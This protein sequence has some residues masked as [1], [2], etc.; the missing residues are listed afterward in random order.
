AID[1]VGVDIHRGEVEQN[2]GAAVADHAVVEDAAGAGLNAGGVA[3]RIIVVHPGVVATVGDLDADAGVE[4][5]G[6]AGGVD[7]VIELKAGAVVVQVVVED[8]RAR[9]GVEV[10]DIH[11]GRVI[12]RLVARNARL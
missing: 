11:A 12:P 4:A 5:R 7:I 3:D 9:C 1:A 10:A 2:P 8:L 6:V